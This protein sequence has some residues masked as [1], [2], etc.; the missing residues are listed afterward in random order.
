MKN[1]I[2]L[3]ASAIAMFAA[4]RCDGG[5]DR[6]R[7]AIRSSNVSTNGLVTEEI[8][9]DMKAAGLDHFNGITGLTPE[10]FALFQKHGVP[11]LCF[12]V[13]RISGTGW[14][15]RFWK[16]YFWHFDRS[17][18]KFRKVHGDCPGAWGVDIG[19]EPSAVVMPQ[20]R[21][22]A[23]RTFEAFPGKAVYLNL[24]PC[25]AR[26]ATSSD[27]LAKSQLGTTNFAD[28]VDAYCRNLPLDYI[29]TDFYLYSS[30]EVNN[31]KLLR[32]YYLSNRDIGSACARTGRSY[33]FYG[34]VNSFKS[35]YP[36]KPTSERMLQWQ[37]LS[38]M[39]YGAEDI[40]W[41][42][43][44]DRGWWTNN[45][46]TVDGRKSEQYEKVKNVNARLHR[47]GEPYMR[48]RRT[49]THLVAHCSGEAAARI[50][51]LGLDSANALDTGFFRGVRASNASPL[52]VGEMSPR[53]GN[54]GTRALFVFSADD[55]WDEHPT[56][57]TVE[58][59]AEGEVVAFGLEGKIGVE[60]DADG[61]CRVPIASNEAVLLVVR[62][63]QAVIDRSAILFGAG[64]V[65]EGRNAAVSDVGVVANAMR[66]TALDYIAARTALF[67]SRVKQNLMRDLRL[68]RTAADACRDSGR[69]LWVLPQA[70]EV[71]QPISDA[72]RRCLANL[73]LVFGAER[74]GMELSGVVHVKVLEE[75]A[76]FRRVDTHF[77]GYEKDW[78][79][80]GLGARVLDELDNGWFMD[81]RAEDFRHLIV[82]E[83]VPRKSFAEERAM[84]VFAEDNPWDNN[85]VPRRVLF[86]SSGR[87]RAIGPNGPVKLRRSENGDYNLLLR[88][89]EAALVI[90]ETLIDR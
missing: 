15:D 85:S 59:R 50:E 31:A 63:K 48:F 51:G 86:K 67:D 34:Q 60:R 88:S 2:V 79:I 28:Y 43:W 18:E 82:A 37:A 55:P 89:N 4:M 22:I 41:A 53:D 65:A 52:I 78:G 20:L 77:I 8:V 57:K 54:S 26:L 70:T 25:Y 39:A 62:N 75:L 17:V 36:A 24:Y 83:L 72:K 56:A 30:M 21:K 73:A 13:M 23:L 61:I 49:A 27:A 47:L 42:C 45:V 81:V 33:W 44:S 3:S 10:G 35:Y 80:A 87:I 68:L 66:T 11:C 90:M 14:G 38:A 71:G 76:R 1:V 9:A 64:A 46:L 16:N 32:Y 58:F 5:F 29:S 40:C 7:F 84:L 12:P 74:V 19:D 69:A 6:G